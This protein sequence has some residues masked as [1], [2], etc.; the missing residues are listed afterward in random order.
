LKLIRT[1]IL[2]VE[3]PY[4]D[5]RSQVILSDSDDR[6][7][8]SYIEDCDI[9]SA[10][11]LFIMSSVIEGKEEIRVKNDVPPSP[12][13]IIKGC[14][15]RQCGIPKDSYGVLNLINSKPQSSEQPLKES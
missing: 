12:C 15:I 9:I 1:R 2:G 7:T 4:L 10:T 11:D 3:D 5:A 13:P 14:I 6:V 8:D